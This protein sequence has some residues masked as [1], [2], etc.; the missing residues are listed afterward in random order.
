[1]NWLLGLG[2]GILIFFI[3][4]LLITAFFIWIGAKL[5]G[6]RNASFGKAIIAALV[7]VIVLTLMVPLLSLTPLGGGLLGLLLGIL[8]SVYIIKAVFDTSWGKAILAWILYVVAVVIAI[9]I[10][11]I[12]GFFLFSNLF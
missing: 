7:S 8:I 11:G 1:M 5:A 6:I 2:T 3:I 12:S 10:M 4:A 9:V